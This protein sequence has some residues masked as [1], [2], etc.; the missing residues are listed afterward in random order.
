MISK[1][2]RVEGKKQKVKVDENSEDNQRSTIASKMEMKYRRSYNAKPYMMAQTAS[3][4]A[5]VSSLPL[6]EKVL[7]K[8]KPND[9]GS[10][11]RPPMKIKMPKDLKYEYKQ[12]P[13]FA[14][15]S[16]SIRQSIQSGIN[17]APIIREQQDNIAALEAGPKS[18]SMAYGGDSAG[19]RKSSKRNA[20]SNNNLKTSHSNASIDKRKVQKLKK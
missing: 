4:S 12:L 14:K 1:R 10:N 5:A 15:T 7:L 2:E 3:A 6:R 17:F 16:A 9:H 18:M 8:A 19:L 13:E 20:S 11:G